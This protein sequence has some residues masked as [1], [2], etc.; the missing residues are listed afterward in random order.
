MEALRAEWAKGEKEE[1][2]KRK[3]QEESHAKVEKTK[4]RLMSFG[5]IVVN[6]SG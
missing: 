3:K 4:I 1:I 6:L 5:Q 2:E